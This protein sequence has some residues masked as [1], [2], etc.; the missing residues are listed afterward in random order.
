[1]MIVRSAHEELRRWLNEQN[2]PKRYVE[3]SAGLEDEDRVM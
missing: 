1:M 3:L 2:T